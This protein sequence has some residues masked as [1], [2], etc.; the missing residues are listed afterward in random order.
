MSRLIYVP[1]ADSFFESSIMQEDLTVRFVML[2]LIRLALRAGANGEVDIDPR[3]F[4]LSINLPHA[5]VDKAVKR[6]MEPDPS[7]SSPDEDGRRLVPVDPERPFRNWR[8]VNWERYRQIVHKSNDAARKREERQKGLSAEVLERDAARTRAV[9]HGGE[10]STDTSEN[11]PV[12]PRPSVSSA[13]NT[14]TKTNTKTNTNTNIKTGGGESEGGSSD[15][16]PAPAPPEL[17][18]IWNENRGGML[19]ARVIEGPRAESARARLKE[20]PDLTV[21]TG[22]IRRAAVSPFCT[23]AGPRSWIAGIDWLLRPGTLGKILEGTFDAPPE[24]H[25]PAAD[26]IAEFTKRLGPGLSLES[27]KTKFKESFGVEYRS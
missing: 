12:R 26:K 20:Q 17:L 25:Y 3:M 10:G 23:G 27:W 11:V 2:A 21:W 9:C 14:K 8:L 5:D 19:P 16:P 1:I 4:A 6:L 15:A 24:D 7:S 22:A 13:T 18:R